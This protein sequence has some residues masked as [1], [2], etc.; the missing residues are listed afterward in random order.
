M[1]P[2]ARR[3]K[4]TGRYGTRG[5]RGTEGRC[6]RPVHMHRA[7]F[8]PR[9]KKR[10]FARGALTILRFWRQWRSQAQA[11][12]YFRQRSVGKGQE[13]RRGEPYPRGRPA[14]HLQNAFGNAPRAPGAP[15][16]TLRCVGGLARL[17]LGWDGVKD[18]VGTDRLANAVHIAAKQTIQGRICPAPRPKKGFFL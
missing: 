12:L 1:R 8:G 18:R 7:V 16:E 15:L 4:G 10:C 13:G 11:R 17:Q 5:K 2:S 9:G 3:I 14:N 6:W